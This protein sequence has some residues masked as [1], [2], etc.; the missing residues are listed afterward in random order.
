MIVG[1]NG[2]SGV[3]PIMTA[4]L[5]TWWDCGSGDVVCVV[6]VVAVAGK[7]AVLT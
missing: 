1:S 4:R 2:G 6:V 7:G 5:L 3:V